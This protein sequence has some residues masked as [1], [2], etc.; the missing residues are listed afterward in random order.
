MTPQELELNLRQF[1]GIENY[2]KWSILFRSFVLTDGAKYLAENAGAYW[3]MDAVASHYGSYKN[4]GFVIAVFG[5]NSEY[6]KGWTLRLVDDIP[7]TKVFATQ[8]IEY[9]DFPLDEIS[10]Y[11]I[12]QDTEL[13]KMWVILLPSEY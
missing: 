7:S 5:K 10:L 12:P 6:H 3:L 13:G 8:N 1:T 4:E 9:S 11:V 2:H